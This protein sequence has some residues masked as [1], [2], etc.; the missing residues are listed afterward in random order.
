MDDS[1]LAA[2]DQTEQALIRAGTPTAQTLAKIQKFSM[3]MFSTTELWNR[4]VAHNAFTN[5]AWKQLK[6]HS[7][8][9][10]PVINHWTNEEYVLP[11][12]EALFKDVV[13]TNLA[14]VRAA[15]G[16]AATQF[17]GGL[18]N[19]PK[20]LAELPQSLSQLSQFP[21]RV[22]NLVARGGPYMWGRVLLGTGLAVGAA[23]LI[24]G[25]GETR[26]DAT[27][28]RSPVARENS[29][30]YPLPPVPPVLQLGGAGAVSALASHALKGLCRCLCPVVWV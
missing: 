7:E 13:A 11:K 24:F 27:A 6:E 12:G 17:G 25:Q 2:I 16:V 14:K 29:P 15:E 8:T 30:F 28:L 3:S 4:S 22:M 9:G 10:K 5:D 26:N 21:L 23:K 18:I 19:K 20:L 1:F